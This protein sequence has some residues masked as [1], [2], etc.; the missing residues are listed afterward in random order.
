MSGHNKWSKI[1]RKKGV[2]DAR[3]SKMFTRILKDIAIAVRE[4]GPDPDANPRLRLALANG[5]GVNLPKDNILRAI[6]KAS[7]SGGAGYTEVTHEGYGPG[8]IAIYVECT[9]DNLNRTLANVRLIMSK[10]GGAL[11]NHGSLSFLFDRKGVFVVPQ[12]TLKEDDF[13]MNVIDAGAE[14]VELDEGVFTVTTS[15]E[16]FGPMQKKLEELGIEA[17]SAELQQVPKT[18]TEVDADTARKVMRLVEFL[19]EDDDVQAVFHNMEL[20]E[21]LAAQLD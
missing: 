3:R 10:H 11:G 14:D 9:T 7:D 1:K 13:T 17:E 15:F 2:T 5:K 19:E 8:G 16:D 20:T 12:G 6:A 4:G 21:A 18:T